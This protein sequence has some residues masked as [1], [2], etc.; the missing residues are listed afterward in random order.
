MKILNLPG[1][2]EVLARGDQWTLLES[3]EDALYF[4]ARKSPNPG[5]VNLALSTAPNIT[6]WKGATLYDTHRN[7]ELISIGME[8]T[9]H[10]PHRISWL[11]PP[12]EIPHIF[13]IYLEKAKFLGR[14]ERMYY[15]S[16]AQF[17]GW[18]I[19]FQWVRDS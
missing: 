15:L 10:G 14:H 3:S 11:L 7:R 12:A 17:F 8:N 13:V 9:D 6:W 18:N 1:E 5:S 19:E 16:A 4:R 2:S